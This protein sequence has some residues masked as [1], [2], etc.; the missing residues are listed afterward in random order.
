MLSIKL[1]ST[2]P[3]IYNHHSHSSIGVYVYISISLFAR[4]RVAEAVC[5]RRYLY[6]RVAEAVCCRMWAVSGQTAN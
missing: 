2:Q 5:C 6:I 1:L 3:S 4:G